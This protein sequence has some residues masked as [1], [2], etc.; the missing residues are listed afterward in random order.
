MVITGS[1]FIDNLA[2]FN[3]NHIYKH[4]GDLTCNDGNTFNSPAGNFPAGLC[5]STR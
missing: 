5:A 1:E 2:P 4:S 3:G